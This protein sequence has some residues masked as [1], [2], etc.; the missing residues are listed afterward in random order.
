MQD[1]K[2]S[3]NEY[4]ARSGFIRTLVR[5]FDRSKNIPDFLNHPI[6]KKI[7]QFWDDHLPDDVKNCLDSWRKIKDEEFELL[8]FNKEEA[9]NYIFEKLGKR[10]LKAYNKCYHPAM[11]SDYFRL[12]YIFSEGGCYIDADD[13]YSG[14]PITELFSDARLKIRPLCYDIS[15]DGMIPSEILINS[16]S[17]NENW[18]YYFN[19]NP[20]IAGPN[21]PLIKKALISATLSLEKCTSNNYPEI[22]ATTGPGNLTKSIQDVCSKNQELESSLA[23]LFEWDKIAESNWQLIYRKDSRNWRLSNRIP[24]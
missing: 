17:N 18:I 9:R 3:E 1:N 16:K 4:V 12:C 22:Q 10:Y 8:L 13:V 11:Q 21:H 24:Y 6:P 5:N 23:I 2:A 15:A 7:I 20:L 19:N 14:W